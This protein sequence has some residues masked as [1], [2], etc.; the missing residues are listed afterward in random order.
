M[1]L[2][3]RDLQKKDSEGGASNVKKF[4]FFLLKVKL[5]QSQPVRLPLQII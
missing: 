1:I 4:C 5:K 3:K 2:N